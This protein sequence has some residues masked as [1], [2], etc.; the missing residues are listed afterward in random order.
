M[1]LGKI[2]IFSAEVVCFLRDILW[3]LEECS[4]VDEVMSDGVSL[5]EYAGCH[6][7]RMSRVAVVGKI[8]KRGTIV[9]VSG[10]HYETTSKV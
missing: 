5:A 4:F 8:F 3:G 9:H 1:I 7:K 10:L 2:M 6:T